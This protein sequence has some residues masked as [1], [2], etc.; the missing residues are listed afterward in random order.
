[1]GLPLWRRLGFREVGRYRRYLSP[2]AA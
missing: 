2:G 1:M